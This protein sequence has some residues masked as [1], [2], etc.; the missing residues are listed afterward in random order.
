MSPFWK[1]DCLTIRGV[2]WR[3]IFL[4][5][6][7]GG[8]MIKQLHIKWLG[9]IFMVLMF[10]QGVSAAPPIMNYEGTL[11]DTS[12]NPVP[13]GSY[14]IQF[15]LYT[16]IT[17]GD[18]LWSEQWDATTTPVIVTNGKF[19]VL[20]GTH[21]PIPKDFF[22]VNP[23]TYIGVTV[24]TDDE[25]APRQQLASVPY[26]LTTAIGK[27]PVGALALFD[28]G[29]VRGSIDWKS[30]KPGNHLV[31]CS[32]KLDLKENDIVVLLGEGRA[33]ASDTYRNWFQII[34]SNIP[35]GDSLVNIGDWGSFGSGI[36]TFEA[37]VLT[38]AIFKILKTGSFQFDLDI[39]KEGSDM[40]QS[41][42]IR[43]ESFSYL[44]FSR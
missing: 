7:K 19:N 42:S 18:A 14:E 25:M 2:F 28:V 31:L 35:E 32:K 5:Q 26:A 23:Q 24:G 4:T 6:L 29:S 17:G 13:D 8:K 9:T 20:L 41:V 38:Y 36:G 39:F 27:L 33:K 3:L 22:N 10:C 44:V 15:S 11:T 40:N 37:S 1:F 16:S 12:G 43:R 21:N 30:V 34:Y